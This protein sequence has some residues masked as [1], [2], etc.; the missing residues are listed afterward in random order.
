MLLAL[1]GF[2]TTTGAVAV[3]IFLFGA[4]FD[5]AYVRAR[6]PERLCA[7]RVELDKVVRGQLLVIALQAL[8]EPRFGAS[9]GSAPVTPAYASRRLDQHFAGASFGPSL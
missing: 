9:R 4:S 5:V 7:H 8:H 3:G 1:R 6:K 2:T